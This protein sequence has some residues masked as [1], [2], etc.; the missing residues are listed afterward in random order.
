MYAAK[1]LASLHIYIGY[2]EPSFLDNAKGVY[3]K[4]K[5]AGSFHIFL[6]KRL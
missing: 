4:N 2:I 1:D 3:T 6:R 5:F